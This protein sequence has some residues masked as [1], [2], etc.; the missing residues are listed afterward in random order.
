M[1]FICC[2]VCHFRYCKCAP[3]PVVTRGVK[4]LQ[5]VKLLWLFGFGTTTR[6]VFVR[7][8]RNV[9]RI[10]LHASIWISN[11]ARELSRRNSDIKLLIHIRIRI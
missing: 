2:S 8:V 10:L 6:S 1:I 9:E 7:S 3:D 5:S 11:Q 4:S